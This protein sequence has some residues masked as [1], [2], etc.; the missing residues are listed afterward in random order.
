MGGF[1][2]I[3][4]VIAGICIYDADNSVFKIKERALD[5]INEEIS[6]LIS[7]TFLNQALWQ[8]RREFHNLPGMRPF[9]RIFNSILSTAFIGQYKVVVPS[10]LQTPDSGKYV[11][12]VRL[13]AERN[14]EYYDKKMWD[15]DMMDAPHAILS[16]AI[17]TAAQTITL[18][19]SKDFDDAGSVKIGLDTLGYS[20]NNKDTGILTLS[21]SASYSHAI[22]RDV[23]Q[24]MSFGLPSR[25][26]VFKDADSSCYVTFN[27]PIE[28]DYE[29]YNI[30]M[31]YY[32]TIPV[33]DSDG[34]IL[35]EPEYDMF[36]SYLAYR[37]KKKKNPSLRKETDPDYTEWVEKKA[38]AIYKE[39]TG[40]SINLIP[41]FH[42]E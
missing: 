2:Y 11:F 39:T 10:D 20:A 41:Q 26:T 1:S 22:G 21:S 7:H 5:S 14:L 6:D 13:G 3:N 40:Q 24:N 25:F 28:D 36:V 37:I 18:L 9:R 15:I 4:C 35:D 16:S 27:I 12:G 17:T 42:D 32:K 31:D 29:G 30:Y 8:A 23:W 33:Y 19:N 34:D 38:M